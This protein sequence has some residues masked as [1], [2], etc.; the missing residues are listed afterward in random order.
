MSRKVT[1]KNR[2]FKMITFISLLCFI[3]TGCHKPPYNDF[4]KDPPRLKSTTLGMGVGAVTGSLLGQPLV[5]VAI[6]GAAGT[7]AG[8]YRSNKPAVIDEIRKQDMQYIEYGDTMTL[9]VPTDHYYQFD[10]PKFND[11]CFAGLN[12]IIRLLRFYPKSHVYVSA[13]SDNVGSNHHKKWLT[14]T[15]ANT[16]LT[17]LWAHNIPARL[18]TAQGY[19]DKYPI[20]NN[21]IIHGSAFNRRIEIQWFNLND[22]PQMVRVYKDKTPKNHAQWKK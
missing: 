19:G 3:L 20:G 17:F 4:D 6:G 1:D 22:K 5:G 12:N 16:M 7:L 9:I 2:L 21:D 8:I 13:F 11:I 14:S 15:R 10:S 18:I